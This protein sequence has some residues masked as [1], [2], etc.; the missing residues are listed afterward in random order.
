MHSSFRF[1]SI[2]IFV[3]A[4]SNLRSQELLNEL[5]DENPSE[6]VTASY[7]NS[8]VINAQSLETTPKRVL[9]FRISHRF[10][11]VN[12]GLYELF[13]LD[14]AGIRIGFDYGITKRLQ[15]GFG[16]SS[17]EKTY[18][19]YLKYR[20]MWQTSDNKVP[21]SIIL[22]SGMSVN[23][24]RPDNSIFEHTFD[25]RLAYSNQMI[26]GRK[27]SNKL[28]LQIMPTIIHRNLV[29]TAE[30]KNTV[31]VIGAAGRFKLLPRLALNAEYF[32]VLPD[33]LTEEYKN[34]FSVGFDIETGGHVFQ[35]HFTNSPIMF[36]KGFI[37][38]TTGRW[39]KGDIHFGF[40]ISRVFNIGRKAKV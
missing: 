26:I 24:L 2:L 12:G 14:D 13:G 36:E 18:D 17:Y 5:E 28:S 31:F 8:R 38:E 9:D 11:R 16:R 30:E 21:F 39:G 7:K 1:A 29:R 10:G 23:S 34:S 33:Q 37:T 4:F 25:M 27:F 32:Y 20:L 19:G 3:F 35:L 15:A 6:H 22:V 40:N